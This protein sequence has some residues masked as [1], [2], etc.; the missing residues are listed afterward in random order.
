MK[1]ELKDKRGRLTA[2][3]LACGYVEKREHG[4]INVTLWREHSCYHVRAYDNELKAC[5]FWLSFN[6]LTKARAHFTGWRKIASG[7]A[8]V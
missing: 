5:R 2:Y 6:S 1:L 3:G 4:A 7:L 8:H